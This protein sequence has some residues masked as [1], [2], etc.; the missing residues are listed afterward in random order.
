MRIAFIAAEPRE[1][2][3]LL[4]QVTRVESPKLPVHWARRGQWR[5][6]DVWLVTNGAGRARAAAAAQAVDAELFVST[7]FCGALDPALE[8]AEIVVATEVIH[9]AARYPAKRV[10][11]GLRYSQVSIYCADTIAGTAKSK[12]ELRKTGAGAVEMEAA[13]VAEVALARGI[14][15]VCVRAVSDLA[16]QTFA[17]DFNRALRSDGHFDTINILRQAVRQPLVRF[18]ELFRLQSRCARASRALGEFFADC[19]F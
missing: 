14:A 11:S 1:F 5:G 17:I 3:G 7:G 15:F 13:G 18:P 12:A 8:I 10:E 16:D 4:P 6:H 9:G 19:R 2:G